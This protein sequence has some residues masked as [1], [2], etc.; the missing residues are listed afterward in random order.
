MDNLSNTL[1]LWLRR[2]IEAI[3]GVPHAERTADA[4]EPL[5][6]RIALNRSYFRKWLVL[7]T[8]IGIVAGIGAIIFYSAIALCTH[9]FLGLGAGF[10][11]PNPAGEGQTIAQPIARPWM[12]PILTT[13]GGLVTGFIVYTFAPEAEGHGTDAA[14]KA[15]HHRGGFIRPRVPLVKT[16]ASAITIGSGGSAGR[17]GP[18]AQIAAGFG[19]TLAD[20]LHL[21]EH[22]RRI[23]MAAGIG[24]GIGSIFKA[25]F[26]GALLSAEVLYTHDLEAEA[27]FPAFIASVVGYSIYGAWAGWTPV[28]GTGHDYAFTQP[29]TLIGF[30]ILGIIAGLV[31][32]LYP[33]TL[34][35]IRDFFA[36]RVKIPPH[37][38]P[39]IGGLAVGLVGMAFPQALGMGYGWVQFGI[40]NDFTQLTALAMLA[41]VFVKI[42]TTALTIG[43]GGSG[44]VFGPGMVIGGFLGAAVWAGLH[45]V[46]P[47]IV[48]FPGSFVVVGMGAFFGGIAKAPLAVILMVAEMTNEYSLIV[49]AMLATMVALL[50]TGTHSIYEE[51]VPT[52]L[53]SPAHKDDYA[54]PLLQQLKVRDAM[55][56]ILATVS[57][58]TSSS[59]IRALLQRHNYISLPVLMDGQLRGIVTADDLTR[60][61]DGFVAFQIMTRHVVVVDPEESLYTAWLRMTQRGF[62]HLPVVQHDAPDNV[63]GEVTLAT[64]GRALRLPQLLGEQDEEANHQPAPPPPSRDTLSDLPAASPT[65]ADTMHQDHLLSGN[66]PTRE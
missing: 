10:V 5:A 43:S 36:T 14:I 65:G 45:R 59:E 17:E 54:L 32:L 48:G 29:I 66:L 8:I 38:K 20:L 9:L 40:N 64:I 51:Q 46:A 23:A 33:L 21:D 42:L 47:G 37:F 19:S 56:P 1:R 58:Q 53:D 6:T 3:L 11:P 25:P 28:F 2:G 35:A 24:A 18:T 55:Q 49:P 57:P 13:L 7:G 34:Y 12:L 4:Q 63:I 27:L 15:F 16:I 52:R 44:G 39:A 61:K 60:A 26:G 41:L 50:I 62:K 30:G 31:S 22:D